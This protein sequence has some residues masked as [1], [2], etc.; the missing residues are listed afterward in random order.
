AVTAPATSK[1]RSACSSIDSGI[2]RIESTNAT[3]PIGTLMKKIHGHENACVSAPPSTRPTAP[4]PAAIADQTPSAL[5]RSL[6]SENVVLMIASAAGEMNAAPRP[7]SA[8]VLISHVELVARPLSSDA[9]V[10][11]TTPA[12]KSR[13]RPSR[14]PRRAAARQKTPLAAEQVP[15][16]AAEQQEAAEH[17]RVG[18]D[19]PLEIGL[20]EPEILLDRGKRNVHDGRVENDHELR[21]T[22]ED[23]DHPAVRRVAHGTPIGK[24]TGQSA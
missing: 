24:R 22:D 8:R 12:R 14:A 13:L 21:E 5:P 19:D 1:F 9:A 23:E 16:A 20:A 15:R 3:A 2:K 17:E 7:W 18:V 10:K 4:P 6:P 11:T